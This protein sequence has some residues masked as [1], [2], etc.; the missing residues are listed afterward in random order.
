M[1]DLLSGTY[2]PDPNPS[3]NVY[4]DGNQ[5]IVVSTSQ[6]GTYTRFVKAFHSGQENNGFVLFE[7][8]ISVSC[9]DQTINLGA[10]ISYSYQQ[11]PNQ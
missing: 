8:T 2:I 5:N 1:L 4:L 6:V 9:K 3:S 10:A 7:V 11:S